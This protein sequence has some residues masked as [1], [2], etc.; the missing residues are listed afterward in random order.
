[1][2]HG[3]RGVELDPKS[4][5]AQWSLSAALESD[6]RYEE[7]AAAADRAL[8]ISGRHCWALMT[9]A[10]IYAS[11]DKPDNARA[12]YSE[13][14]A[15]SARDY[16]QPTALAVGAAAVGEMDRAI[17]FVQQAL[18]TEIPLLVMM[19]RSW[20]EYDRLRGDSRFN[21]IVGRLAFPGSVATP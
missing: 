12:V 16:I 2:E 19:A 15:R 1:V 4:Y 10:S 6:D 13:M 9:L 7:A 3:R 11:W 18:T 21:E 8:A 14:E 5:L 17:S 20:P